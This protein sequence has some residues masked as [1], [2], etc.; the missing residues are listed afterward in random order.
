MLT[1]PQ[2]GDRGGEASSTRGSLYQM[3]LGPTDI[4]VNSHMVAPTSSG[5]GHQLQV[6]IDKLPTTKVKI[7]PRLGSTLEWNTELLELA[8]NLRLTFDSRKSLRTKG[9][10][11][12]KMWLLNLRKA[13]YYCR[14]TNCIASSDRLRKNG[15]TRTQYCTTWSDSQ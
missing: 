10:P 2:V 13:V 8:A 1:T 7:K 6:D 15:G 12:R 11:L 4:R 3:L 9:L 14:I 5:R